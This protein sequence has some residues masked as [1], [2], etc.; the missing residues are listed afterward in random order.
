MRVTPWPITSRWRL[1]H[2]AA[3]TIAL[4]DRLR[5][6]ASGIATAAVRA[7]LVVDGRFL[8][9][10]YGHVTAAGEVAAARLAAAGLP[11]VDAVYAAKA[12]AALLDLADAGRGPLLLWLTKSSTPLARASDA[13]LDQAPAALRRWLGRA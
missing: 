10:G 5:G 6:R 4:A 12:S 11:A 7:S 2:L 13:E 3:R 8:G 1:A 9:A